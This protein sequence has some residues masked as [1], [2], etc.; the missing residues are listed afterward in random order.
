MRKVFSYR[1]PFQTECVRIK[2]QEVVFAA[3]ESIGT[4]NVGRHFG[5]VFWESM[6]YIKNSGRIITS[7][8]HAAGLRG[9]W[10]SER[11]KGSRLDSSFWFMFGSSKGCTT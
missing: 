2:R 3:R 4:K 5:I 10:T 8:Y 11:D 6:R 7:A 1:G 9:L